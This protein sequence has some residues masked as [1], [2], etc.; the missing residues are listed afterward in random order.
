[1]QGAQKF[2]ARVQVGGGAALVPTAD[3]EQRKWYPLPLQSPHTEPLLARGKQRGTM[4]DRISGR[5]GTW[6]N[7]SYNRCGLFKS[8][9]PLL[10]KG[11]KAGSIN[12]GDF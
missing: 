12:H 4:Q 5:C 6:G 11:R 9:L 10:W 8:Y 7:M 3:A 1:M 2:P